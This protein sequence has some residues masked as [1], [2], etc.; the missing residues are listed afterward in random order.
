MLIVTVQQLVA[1]GVWQKAADL[2]G[3]NPYALKEGLISYDETLTLNHTQFKQLGVTLEYL[4][5]EPVPANSVSN[6]LETGLSERFYLGYEEVIS[7]LQEREDKLITKLRTLRQ[8]PY[9]NW[10]ASEDAIE[11]VN[12]E[13]R[14]VNA[15]VEEIARDLGYDL[16][17]LTVSE[18]F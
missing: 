4:L 18:D 17:E 1:A 3:L 13:R 11:A 9:E 14:F 12:K 8:L 15:V 7:F 5:R 6:S 10:R 2:I 16:G